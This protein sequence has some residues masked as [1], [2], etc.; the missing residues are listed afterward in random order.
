MVT[1]TLRGSRLVPPTSFLPK[2][3]PPHQL[4]NQR[5]DALRQPPL[6]PLLAGVQRIRHQGGVDRGT[7]RRQETRAA[8]QV[9]D[10]VLAAGEGPA[11]RNE[12]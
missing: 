1:R 8:V 6:L 7:I 10:A 2:S 11:G 3:L 4:V 9:V 12:E 5:L